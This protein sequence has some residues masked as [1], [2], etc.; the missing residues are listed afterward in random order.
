MLDAILAMLVSGKPADSEVIYGGTR[1]TLYRTIID[2]ESVIT[3]Q[4]KRPILINAFAYTTIR[5]S[6]AKRSYRNAMKMI[7]LGFNS[8]EPIAWAELRNGLKLLDSIYVCLE[9]K[10]ATE[11]REWQ[12]LPCADTLVPAFAAEIF[13]LHQAGVFHKDFSPG[14]IL[15]IKNTDGSYTFN[16]VDLNRMKFGVHDHASQ[17]RMFRAINLNYDALDHLARKYA[18]IAGEDEETI[19]KEAKLELD[20][21]FK[22]QKQKRLFKDH[23]H[24]KSK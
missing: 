6:K 1:N 8:P 7:S 23:L 14:N 5:K 22:E 15:F 13:R 4:F 20:G 11:M 16:Y 17:M 12:E 21:Y 19:A 24:H 9:L 10:G 18:R 3:K 2:G